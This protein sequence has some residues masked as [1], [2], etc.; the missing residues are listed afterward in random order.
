MLLA[1][2]LGSYTPAYAATLLWDAQT[3]TSPLTVERSTAQT[4][5][6]TTIATLPSGATSFV[7][8]PGVYGWYRVVNSAGPSNSVQFSLD[9]FTGPVT[10]RLDVLEARVNQLSA[11]TPPPPAPVSNFTVTQI[12]VDHVRLVCNGV[13]IATTGTGTTRTLECRH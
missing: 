12:D 8:T 3:V 10:T 1:L 7:L 2:L 11:P 13:S 4:G 6:Y 5:P 9:L